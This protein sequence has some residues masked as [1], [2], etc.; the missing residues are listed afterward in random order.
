VHEGPE[1][2]DRQVE[3]VPTVKIRAAARKPTTGMASACEAMV[4][5]TIATVP[6]PR[7]RATSR[8]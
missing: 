7:P 3:E 4:L 1:Q 6:L 2:V 5:T 8:E